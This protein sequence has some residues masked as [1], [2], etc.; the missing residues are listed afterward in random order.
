MRARQKILYAPTDRTKSDR[1]GQLFSAL[2]SQVTEHHDGLGSLTR[3]RS[4][5]NRSEMD[6]GWRSWVRRRD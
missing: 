3:S 5:Q 2:F 1:A 4:R 6:G